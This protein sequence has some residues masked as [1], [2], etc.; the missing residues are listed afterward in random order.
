MK[1][2]FRSDLRSVE[3][4]NTLRT[5][6]S[7]SAGLMCSHLVLLDEQLDGLQVVSV[8]GRLGHS[9]PLLDPQLEDKTQESSVNASVLLKAALQLVRKLQSKSLK[10]L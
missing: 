7:G 3:V 2:D 5:L 6:L 10:T 9:H 1:P 8:V 4:F